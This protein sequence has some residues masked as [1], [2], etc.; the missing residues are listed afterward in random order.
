MNR[1]EKARRDMKKMI[2]ESDDYRRLRTLYEEH[3][4]IDPSKEFGPW[5]KSH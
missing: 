1:I 4:A 2:A 3:Q 5:T